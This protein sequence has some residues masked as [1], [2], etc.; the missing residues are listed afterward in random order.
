[1]P[2]LC[3]CTHL[4]DTFATVGWLGINIGFILL[5]MFQKNKSFLW[6][7]AQSINSKVNEHFFFAYFENEYIEELVDIVLLDII[8][9]RRDILIKLYNRSNF[10]LT[11]NLIT[12][13]IASTPQVHNNTIKWK[14]SWLLHGQRNSN[15]HGHGFIVLTSYGTW[16]N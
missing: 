10:T 11:Y 15:L 3:I 7:V 13:S 8:N 1:M 4:K 6:K 2:S 12:R 14:V 5:V 16:N 9:F